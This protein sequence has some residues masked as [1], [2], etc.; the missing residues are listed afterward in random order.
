[1]PPRLTRSPR[2][3]AT[4]RA[5]STPTSPTRMSCSL[6][7][8]TSAWP[9]SSSRSK[10]CTP[11]SRPR[12]ACRYARPDRAGVRR[13]PRLRRAQPRVLAVR[14]ANPPPEAELAERYRQLGPPGRAHHQALRPAP[15]RPPMPPST[16]PRWC[17]PRHRPVPPVLR[18]ARRAPWELHADAIIQLLDLPTLAALSRRGV[19]LEPARAGPD[20]SQRT[21]DGH[22]AGAGADPGHR[23]R[24]GQGL[25]RRPGRLPRRPGR[26][27]RRAVPGRPAH[28]AR[29]GLLH[30]HRHRHRRHTPGSVQALHLVVADIHATR[31]GSWTAASRSARSRR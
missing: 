8:W 9:P 5:P 20:L 15:D 24:P 12:S 3:P 17:S 13:G 11:S 14:H 30:L 27:L 22:E 4:P 31:A 25:L 21:H 7:C 10:R 2:R 29:L 23:R 26:A 6:R 18:R 28:P 19:R 1:M 16:W